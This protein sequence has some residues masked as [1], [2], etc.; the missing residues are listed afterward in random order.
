MCVGAGGQRSL[1]TVFTSLQI[2]THSV[3]LDG[4]EMQLQSVMSQLIGGGHKRPVRSNVDC[5][6][7]SP[8]SFLLF[9]H[10]V[11]VCLSVSFTACKS[12]VFVHFMV[13]HCLLVHGPPLP[14]ETF[15]AT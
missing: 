8:F 7:S 2:L 4:F 6:D 3:P 12:C 13:N 11:F 14:S 9:D 5:C 1:C 10:V 15:H